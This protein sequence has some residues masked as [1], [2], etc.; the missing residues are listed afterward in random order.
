MKKRSI[1]LMVLMAFI[2]GGCSRA[3]PAED[4]GKLFVDRVVYD[5]DTEK[6]T[7]NF[8]NGEELNKGFK[9][10][11]KN[12][13]DN[14]TAGLISV[15]DVVPEDKADELTTLLNKQIKDVTSYQ[16]EIKAAGKIS[17]V[18]YEV[19][20]LDFAAIMKETS[21]GITKKMIAD[22]KLASDQ[23]KIIEETL[24]LLKENIQKAKA[25]EKAVPIM[26]EM[27]PEKGK[28][29]VVRGQREQINNLY[30]AFVAGVKDQEALTNE[31]NQAMAEVVK[32]V[33]EELK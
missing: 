20:G 17:N 24:A 15:G 31:W 26:I 16:V 14:F 1:F 8:A 29:T 13:K 32:E 30:F 6:F 2:L 11:E 9:E 27:K 28:W 21:K 33:Q 18:T 19:K 12:F 7:E 23:N 10:N 25:K 4:A 5:K 22:N 3:I